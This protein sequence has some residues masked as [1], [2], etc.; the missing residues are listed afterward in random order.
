MKSTTTMPKA[1][2]P[3]KEQSKTQIC[4]KGSF[5]FDQNVSQVTN[6]NSK[7]DRGGEVQEPTHS[8]FW[9]LFWTVQ[10]VQGA[11]SVDED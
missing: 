8:S 9:V 7:Q 6:L 5:N 10:E 1:N 11:Q 3:K 2:S 4:K